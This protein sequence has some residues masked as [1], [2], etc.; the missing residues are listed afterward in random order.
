MACIVVIYDGADAGELKAFEQICSD[1]DPE[2]GTHAVRRLS[3][4]AYWLAS[5]NVSEAKVVK[6][7]HAITKGKWY[8]VRAEDDE[9]TAGSATGR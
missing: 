6:L 8:C 1:V 9:F 4:T 7:G 2:C 3:P 5:L